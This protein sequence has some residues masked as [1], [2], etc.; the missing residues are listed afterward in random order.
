MKKERVEELKAKGFMVGDVQDLFREIEEAFSTL[1]ERCPELADD[2]IRETLEH[3]K[4]FREEHD[5]S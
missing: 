3:V 5:C 1:I 4:E 2:Q